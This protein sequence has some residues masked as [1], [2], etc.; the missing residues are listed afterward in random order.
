M[1]LS[2]FI[3]TYHSK[4]LNCFPWIC[5]ALLTNSEMSVPR[6]EDKQDLTHYEMKL[7]TKAWKYSVPKQIDD[8]IL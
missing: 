2:E 7:S 4:L 6:E 8:V 1:I 3:V 5:S